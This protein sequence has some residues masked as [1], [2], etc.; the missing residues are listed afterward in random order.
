MH[1]SEA[2]PLM[3]RA[4]ASHL[5]TSALTLIVLLSYLVFVKLL[6][7]L[8]PT[9]LASAQQA[10]ALGWPA[11]ALYWILA[12]AGFWLSSRTGFPDIWDVRISNQRR[13]LFP[14]LL[15]LGLGALA[16][17]GDFTTGWSRVVAE[18]LHL[19]T[20][21]IP[22]PMS[23]AIYPAGGIITDILFRLFPL[24]LLVFLISNLLLRK[25]APNATFW[26]SAAVLS[27]LEGLSSPEFI[28]LHPG[29]AAY[30]FFEGYLVNFTQAA[31]FRKLGFFSCAMVRVA[32]YVVWHILWGGWIQPAIVR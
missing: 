16:V 29:L 30:I 27:C 5:S 12:W 9:K 26:S 4:H 28:R 13:I 23:A 15:G 10:Q 11:I 22:L 1:D 7:I 20:I 8:S 19:A 25:R 2:I 6:L 14:V 17:V 3:S 31:V 32:F 24:P 18:R 21:H